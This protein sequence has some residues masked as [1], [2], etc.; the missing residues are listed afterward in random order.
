MNKIEIWNDLDY[1]EGYREYFEENDEEVDWD[2]YWDYY[3]EDLECK[4]EG[5]NDE[6][7]AV[8]S[9]GRWDGRYDGKSRVYDSITEL[10][11][12]FI[13]QYD[14]YLTINLSDNGELYLTYCH[15]DGTDYFEVKKVNKEICKPMIN[16][17]HWKEYYNKQKKNIMELI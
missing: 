2:F 6:Y 4:F 9:L 8:G 10:I 13:S 7:I 14:G 3:K 5:N 15:H 1:Q 17:Y 16:G 11:I 12:D